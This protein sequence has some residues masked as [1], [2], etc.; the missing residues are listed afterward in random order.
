VISQ[1]M[2]SMVVSLPILLFV[3][4]YLFFT[5]VLGTPF[6]TNR[7]PNTVWFMDVLLWPIGVVS[8][9]YVV[10]GVIRITELVGVQAQLQLLQSFTLHIA[11]FWLIARGFD[12]VF[13]RWFVFHRT[14][15]TTPALLRGLT[16]A[17]FLIAAFSLFLIRMG[18]PITG[19]LVSTGV[20]VGIVGLALQSTLNDLFSGIALSLEKPFHIGE[21]IELE[22][23]TVGQVIDLTWRSTRLKTF[24]NTILSIPN[25]KMAGFAIN[26]LDRPDGAYGIWYT[27]RVSANVDPTLVVTVLSTALSHCSHVL[28]KPTPTVR[29]N[30]ASSTPYLYTVWV[31][32]RG[33]LA[34]FRGQEQLYM[35]IHKALKNAGVSP[36]GDI[37]EIRY[38]R[39]TT[40]NPINPSIADSLRSLDIF[41]E[42]KQNEIDQIAKDSEYRLVAA[43]TVLLRENTRSRHVYVVV[44]GSLESSITIKNGQRA[45]AEQFSTGDSFGWATIVTDQNAIM[46]VRATSDSL[47]LV[48][49]GEC[50]QP[51]LQAHESL[52]QQ[53]Y[54]L[55]TERIN[56]LTHI[57][58]EALE[59][60]R[61]LSPSEIRR[62]IERFVAGGSDQDYG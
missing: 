25:S 62:R 60:R 39:A 16:Y 20:A 38:S 4:A 48:I 31:H 18:Y 30:D 59:E 43:D 19:F 61:S 45:P 52:R 58:N 47:V 53:F 1:F 44:N 34:H 15:F 50:L 23:K 55:V 17:L 22:N 14:G 8:F 37:Q 21:W 12:L 9:F 36:V 41:S 40:L 35:E 32:Y 6:S 2:G 13:L 42:L 7:N 11:V 29:L 10:A 27:L 26:N 54:D 3:L 51:I 33:Y 28:P 46:S 57:R 5:R 24:N 49:N 56:Q